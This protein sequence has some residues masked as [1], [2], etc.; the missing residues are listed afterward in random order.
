[1]QANARLGDDFCRFFAASVGVQAQAAAG[2]VK[3]AQHQGAQPGR[4]IG[5]DGGQ[6]WRVNGAAPIGRAARQQGEGGLA[7]RLQIMGMGGA[8]ELDIHA[9]MARASA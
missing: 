3:A 4:A 6:V 8:G 2:G 7:R 1:M 5:A 9:I